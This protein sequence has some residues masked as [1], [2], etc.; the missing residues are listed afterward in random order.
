MGRTAHPRQGKITFKTWVD[1]QLTK[2]ITTSH[3]IIISHR[4]VLVYQLKQQKSHAALWTCKD[5]WVA[6][7]RVWTR[8]QMVALLTCFSQSSLYTAGYW[9]QTTPVSHSQS[10]PK[11][12]R[13]LWQPMTSN[14][15]ISRS[16]IPTSSPRA[17]SPISFPA[18]SPV[19]KE[20]PSRIP[21]P[22]KKK[23]NVKFEMVSGHSP[24]NLSDTDA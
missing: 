15:A 13:R 8:G 10:L 11:K 9:H 7:F 1:G 16:L 18:S 4:L 23:G 20:D 12:Q 14:P 24:F 21:P 22:P 6:L 2:L 17:I 5:K 19:P 3:Q